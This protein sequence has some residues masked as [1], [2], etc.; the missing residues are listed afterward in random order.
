[1]EKEVTKGPAFSTKQIFE[2]CRKHSAEERRQICEEFQSDIETLTESMGNLF[3][4]HAAVLMMYGVRVEV[5]M[6]AFNDLTYTCTLGSEE[7][8][9]K[10]TAP[11]MA[12]TPKDKKG[13]Q[14][15]DKRA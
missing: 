12:F 9:N 11:M 3:S 14:N 5:K 4:E 8:Y 13:P 15:N 10:V 6:Y 7:F 1:M 2:E